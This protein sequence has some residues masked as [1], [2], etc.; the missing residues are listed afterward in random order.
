M[1]DWVGTVLNWELYKK[2]RFDQE[3]QTVDLS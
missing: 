2:F 1:E 3:D